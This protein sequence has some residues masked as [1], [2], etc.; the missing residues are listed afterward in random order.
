MRG[1][2]GPHD[3]LDTF[4]PKNFIAV[5][6]VI[7]NI[8]YHKHRTDFTVEECFSDFSAQDFSD[9]FICLSGRQTFT[10]FQHLTAY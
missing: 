9:T 6:H 7:G 1:N 4:P 5:V 3:L 8:S 2:P 10:I